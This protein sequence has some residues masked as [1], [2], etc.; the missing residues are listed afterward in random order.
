MSTPD[1]SSE[2]S[3]ENS[4]E[5]DDPVKFLQEQPIINQLSEK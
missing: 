4:S 3:D 1:D 2:S 5:D